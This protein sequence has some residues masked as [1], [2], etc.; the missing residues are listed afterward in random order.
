MTS[1]PPVPRRMANTA[2]LAA[3]ADGRNGA[4]WKLEPGRRDLDANVIALAP[5]A[6]I[7]EHVGPELDVLL[8]VVAGSGLLH[9][10]GTTVQLGAGDI[11]YLPARARRHFVAGEQGLSYFSVHQRKKTAGL[12]P[13]HRP[14]ET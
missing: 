14:S 6:E 10:E 5:G 4:L 2:E 11:I 1:M 9:G 8:H 12:M 7:G 13:A 3:Q